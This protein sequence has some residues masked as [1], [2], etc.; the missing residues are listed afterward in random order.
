LGVVGF[1][2]FVPDWGSGSV[3]ILTIMVNLP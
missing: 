1:G 3:T 2:R